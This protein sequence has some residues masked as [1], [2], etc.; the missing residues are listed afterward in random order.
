LDIAGVLN[1]NVNKRRCLPEFMNIKHNVIKN[2]V[3]RS[4]AL[5]CPV[6]IALVLS[7]RL[8][9][10][11][12][13]DQSQAVS[14]FEALKRIV[15]ETPYID[16]PNYQVKLKTF[17]KSGKS[18]DNKLL[19]A[20]R[21]TLNDDR[22]LIDFPGG[23]KLLQANGI[24]FSG[25]WQIDTLESPYTGLFRAGASS[26]VIVRASVALSGTL[27]KNKRAFGMAVKLLPSDLGT[28]P[29]L[30]LF[31]LNS[32]GGAISK[33]V[34]DLSMDNQ[35]PLGRVP[36]F[37]DIRTALRMRN[38]LERADK[39]AI[40]EDR[41]D[42]KPKATFRPV[43]HVAAYREKIVK[44]PYWIR[45]NAISEHRNN[46]NDFRDELRLAAYPDNELVYGIE[47]ADF[48]N[49]RKN[50]ADWR[51]IGRLFLTDSVTSAV[52]DQ[53]LHFRHP[54]LSGENNEK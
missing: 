28:D 6:L 49:G 24:C 44:S 15:F 17:G 39:E 27:Q 45:F 50:Q 11:Q 18:E 41:A 19:V 33:H 38:E 12:G 13:S 22:D 40:D 51:Q 10:Q 36:K 42:T 20:A 47:V 48:G 30:N 7:P 9:A 37:S 54:R 16:L 21:R 32:L 14:R 43:T 3:K 23:Q 25:E 2:F 35:P 46:Q 34:L 52:C 5:I 4:L 53:K 8:M 31:V 29:S 1:K 26:P